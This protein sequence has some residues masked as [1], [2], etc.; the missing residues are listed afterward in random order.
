[1][2]VPKMIFGPEGVL[3]PGVV[4]ACLAFFGLAVVGPG[5]ALQRLLRLRPDPALVL[6]IGLACC[7]GSYWLSLGV[8]TPALFP[9]ATLALDLC[10]LLP[11]GK[12][13]WAEGPSLRGAWPPLLALLVLLAVEEYPLNRFSTGGDFVVDPWTLEDSTFHAGLA[14]ELSHTYPPQVPGL[15]GFSFDYHFGLPLVRAAALR[16]A[17]VH[18]YDALNRCDPTLMGIALILALRGAARVLTARPLAADL[19]GWIPLATNLSWLFLGADTQRWLHIGDVGLANSGAP[20]LAMALGVVLALGRHAA[21]EGL[22][23]RVVALALSLATPFF[24][25]FVAAHLLLALLMAAVVSNRWRLLGPPLLLLT[26]A[27]GGLV[28]G[29]GA[30]RWSVGIDPLLPVREF[31]AQLGATPASGPMLAVWTLGWVVGIVGVRLWGVPTAVRALASR[32]P[33]PSIL[34]SLAL[35]GWVLGLLFRITLAEAVRGRTAVNEANYFID[36]S[37]L[38]LWVFVAAGLATWSA[39]KLRIAAVGVL[40]V[41]LSISGTLWRIVSGPPGSDLPRIPQ[42]ITKA[43]ATLAAQSEPGEVVL[44]K[45]LPRPYPPPALV[46]IGLRVPFTRTISYLTQF[47]GRGE[48]ESRRRTVQRFFETTDA[49]EAQAIARSLGARYLCLVE[50]D[51]VRFPMA[52]TLQLLSKRSRVRLYRILL[53]SPGP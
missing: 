6:P 41:A 20:A 2:L 43:M 49:N 23:W 29:A 4:L 14:W 34:A 13:S 16:W 30:G 38:V 28:L 36:Q 19:A 15:S 3:S 47:A 51:A 33:T 12:W 27:T 32:A 25:V 37:G 53:G 46:L 1:M 17:H 8:G 40:C 24:K 35:S 52:R 44:Q 22:G 26:L 7:A 31:A 21:G 39:P 9:G 42:A 10:L 48:I 11:L 50:S 45:P 5:L 18:P